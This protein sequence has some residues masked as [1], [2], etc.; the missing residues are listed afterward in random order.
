MKHDGETL[1]IPTWVDCELN[2]QGPDSE[3]QRPLQ[4]PQRVDSESFDDTRASAK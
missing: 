3:S 1:T 2:F 4:V